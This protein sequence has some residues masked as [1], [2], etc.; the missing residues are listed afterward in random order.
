MFCTMVIVFNGMRLSTEVVTSRTSVNQYVDIMRRPL[1]E[2]QEYG[3][4]V[5][6]CPVSSY[7]RP[8]VT[9]CRESMDWKLPGSCQE[10][11]P[12]GPL[13]GMHC[14]PARRPRAAGAGPTERPGMWAASPAAPP[15][16]AQPSWS[17]RCCT[18][19]SAQPLPAGRRRQ[20]IKAGWTAL[21]PA[22][23]VSP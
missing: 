1:F 19:P 6:T 5:R 10:G 13:P 16:G 18:G 17:L 9:F 23:N 21:L 2:P 14:Q 12:P 11:A 4:R 20:A 15:P 8:L 7:M 3:V 22:H